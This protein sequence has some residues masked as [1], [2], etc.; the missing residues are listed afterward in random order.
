MGPEAREQIKDLGA[1][2]MGGLTSKVIEYP[3]DTV[4]VRLQT[5]DKY[6]GPFHCARDMARTEGVSSLFRGIAAPIGGAMLETSLMFWAYGSSARILF[7]G[8]DN[9]TLSQI[10]LCGALTGF[11]IASWLTPVEYLKCRLQ[12]AHTAKLYSGIGGCLVHTVREDGLSAL[13]RGGFAT[14]LREVPGGAV[15]F[16]AYELM[17]RSLT[18]KGEKAST[19]AIIAGGGMAGLS[20]WSAIMPFDVIKSKMQTV[21]AGEAQFPGVIETA[22][23]IFNKSGVRGFY[24][25]LLVTAPRA[26]LSNAVIF[27]TYDYFRGL[28]ENV[29]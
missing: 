24:T 1:G 16:G 17:S 23:K 29:F 26:I 10:T 20:Y 6:T 13:F 8:K 12:A 15:Y 22:S 2:T 19:L 21:S 14:L 18:K 3:F 25:G 5:S 11:P 27:T 9:L 7:G 4:K 28:L